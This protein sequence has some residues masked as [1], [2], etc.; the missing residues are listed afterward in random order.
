MPEIYALR[1]VFSDKKHCL[2]CPLRD[3]ETDGCRVQN[4]SDAMQYYTW[5]DRMA[6]CPLEFKM[7][8]DSDKDE[9]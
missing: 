6:K 5:E 1:I 3:T 8:I 9:L 4:N 7:K 2:K